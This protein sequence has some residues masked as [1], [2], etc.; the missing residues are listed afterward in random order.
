M[1]DHGL[2]PLPMQNQFKIG[3][4][5]KFFICDLISQIFAAHTTTYLW[6]NI[7]KQYFAL[8]FKNKK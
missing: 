7:G 6:L 5:H 3:F 4:W 2:S 8:S 1:Y